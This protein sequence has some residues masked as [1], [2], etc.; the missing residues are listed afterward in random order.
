RRMR[1]LI[2]SAVTSLCR[3]VF[4]TRWERMLT[5]SS[6]AR[7]RAPGRLIATKSTCTNTDWYWKKGRRNSPFW[8]RQLRTAH[9]AIWPFA[10][11]PTMCFEI[12]GRRRDSR[13]RRAKLK[14]ATKLVRFENSSFS[15]LVSVSSSS[16][17][18]LLG[19]G[20]ALG[21]CQ[22]LLEV[23]RQLLHPAVVDHGDGQNTLSAHS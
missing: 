20:I 14:A 19:E 4:H 1:S 7:R 6:S 22:L 2:R 17:F 9:S 13:R 18:L 12:A 8:G 16:S 11:P 10:R 5:P 21:R 3:R 15:A 23:F